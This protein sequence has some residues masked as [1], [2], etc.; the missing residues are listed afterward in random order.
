MGT[1]DRGD[2][3]E[4]RLDRH[5]LGR[6]LGRSFTLGDVFAPRG[7]T[8]RV[9]YW[10]ANATAFENGAIFP[11]TPD[12]LETYGIKSY[13][14]R[15][16]PRNLPDGSTG[17]MPLSVGLKASASFPVAIPPTTLKSG[18]DPAHP[19]L[20]LMDG[21]VSDNLGVITAA[22][23]LRQD[24]APRKIMILIDAYNG[25]TEPFSRIGKGPG[26]MRAALRTTSISLDSAHQRN[27]NLIEL[28]AKN[29]GAE[30]ALIDFHKPLEEYEAYRKEYGGIPFVE[31]ARESATKTERTSPQSAQALFMQVVGVGTW[32]TVREKTQDLL[33]EAG[34]SAT[35][36]VLD[37]NGNGRLIS[38]LKRIQS[39]F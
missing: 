37:E 24:P 34:K 2:F 12:V 32:L 28:V 7:T 4:E 15:V 26:M 33:I 21:G 18:V 16:R 5:L 8:P 1:I 31:S 20:H 17:N 9:P 23:L 38:E 25:M 35:R 11:F 27:R 6:R 19:N 13:W 14:H 36:P 39:M 3:L 29:V 10:I 22:R 30:I